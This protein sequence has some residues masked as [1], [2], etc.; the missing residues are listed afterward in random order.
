MRTRSES[1]RSRSRPLGSAL[2]AALL[3]GALV[4]VPTTSARTLGTITVTVSGSGTVAG[5][6]ISC[7][8]D[9]T[10]DFFGP[11][12]LGA[13][14]DALAVFKGWGGACANAGTS[15]SCFLDVGFGSYSVSASFGPIVTLPPR[16]A[17]LLMPMS[18]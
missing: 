11:A 17:P 3:V 1:T 10:G 8:G 18:Q 14:P 7:P 6:G 5:P 13:T 9:C 2:A 12:V 4:S 16:Y 15:T